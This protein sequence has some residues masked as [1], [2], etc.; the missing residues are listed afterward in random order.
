MCVLRNKIYILSVMVSLFANVK[1][2]LGLKR[3]TKF[4]SVS[5]IISGP[6]QA[7]L[8]KHFGKNTPA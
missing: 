8:M 5:E 3:Y 6:C 1:N 7:S 2:A 4:Q